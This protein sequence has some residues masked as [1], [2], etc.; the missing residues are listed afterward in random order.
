MKLRL[1][2]TLLCISLLTGCGGKTPPPQSHTADYNGH[3]VH[4]QVAGSGSKTIVFIHG[5]SCD[6]EF[7][8][9]Q[10]PAFGDDYRVILIDLPGHGKSD[11]PEMDYTMEA[12][13][14]AVKAV[15]DDSSTEK[16][17]VIGHSMGFA[18][19]WQFAIKYPA[20]TAGVCSV[21][22]AFVRIPADPVELSTLKQNIEMIKG[23]LKM[24]DRQAFLTAFLESMYTEKTTPQIRE[25]IMNKM[26]ATPKHV[27]DSA[28]EDLLDLDNWRDLPVLDIPTLAVYVKGPDYKDQDR[29]FIHEKFTKL[30]FH[31][32]EDYSHFFMLENPDYFNANL[33]TFLEANL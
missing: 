3:K 2:L 12:F 23:G 18:V 1:L 20:H 4:Y 32:I 16:A 13:A 30:D 17:V 11:A 21:D 28:M 26:S 24:P 8:K 33:K 29:A 27:G 9:Y 25:F 10:V 22:G 15:L 19:A 14:D 6:T 7:W 5:W 31:E